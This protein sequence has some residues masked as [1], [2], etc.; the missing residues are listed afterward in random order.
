MPFDATRMK[1]HA[2][3][4]VVVG[5]LVVAALGIL[6]FF[7]ALRPC[8]MRIESGEQA[9]F[10]LRSEIAEI[11]ADGSEGPLQVSDQDLELIGID[12][13]N[14]VML[15]SPVAGH[16][17]VTLM[18]FTA[19]GTARTLD[20]AL[21]PSEVGKA[22][23][24]FDFN[25]MPL[26]PG[27]EQG[28]NTD[29]VYA[30]LPPSKRCVQ[31]KVKRTRSGANPEFQLKL[32]TSVEWI[33][34]ENRYIQVRDLVCSYRYDT[35]KALVDQAVLHCTL[36]IE[37]EDGRH[38][39]RVRVDLALV[40]IARTSDDPREVR[41]LALAACEAQA[42]LAR[43]SNE[44]FANILLR[45]QGANIQSPRLRDLVRQL[46]QEVR[47]PQRPTQHAASRQLW[48]VQLASCPLERRADADS[49]TR[50]LITGGLHAWVGASGDGLAVLIGPYYD[51]DPA[52]LAQISQHYPQQRA[53]WVRIN[54]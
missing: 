7:L 24:Y 45:L 14:D 33:S 37:R 32:P 53:S 50:T 38:R 6:A 12:A 35:G 47:N 18:N 11:A 52:V 43:G 21:R 44:R 23:G 22:L 51:R 25:L 36:G 30:C 19:A 4:L 8:R 2:A 17:E 40:G 15:L 16:D 27:V 39:F 49:F 29:L 10:H 42:A 31:G 26:P 46:I 41:D 3:V 20:A 28:W 54:P 5:A 34:A 48:A 9:T 1:K 13:D